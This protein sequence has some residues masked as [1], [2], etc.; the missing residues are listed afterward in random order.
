MNAGY[1]TERVVEA[2]AHYEHEAFTECAFNYRPASQ[3]QKPLYTHETHWVKLG[4]Q[5][6][7]RPFGR[8]RTLVHSNAK[9]CSRWVGPQTQAGIQREFEDFACRSLLLE[10][11]VFMR[12]TPENA[13]KDYDPKL[14]SQ[15]YQSMVG[16]EYPLNM[17][18]LAMTLP[19]GGH[20]RLDAW[21]RKFEEWKLEHGPDAV[22]LADN[23][24][25][26]GDS[27][28]QISNYPSLFPALLCH[29]TV[30]NFQ[31]EVI[32]TP[33]EHLCAMGID[34]FAEP[35]EAS[36][37]PLSELILSQPR[38]LSVR[39]IGNGVHVTLLAY[40]Y[41]YCWSNTRRITNPEF[42]KLPPPYKED[43]EELPGDD[44]T[45]SS[46]AETA[47]QDPLEQQPEEQQADACSISSGFDSLGDVPQDHMDEDNFL[48]ALQLQP[49]SVA[50]EERADVVLG[51][52]DRDSEVP[53]H[54]A[55]H[56]V[57]SS[58][59]DNAP[60]PLLDESIAS[61]VETM[62]PALPGLPGIRVSHQA[63]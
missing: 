57:Q 47:L 37:S 17:E 33:A 22:F 44:D 40:W 24:H 62:E 60:P 4:P 10:G 21:D 13:R 61:F 16:T 32:A 7:G 41:V 50:Q 51:N 15:K 42:D 19:A 2:E 49:E 27:G 29:G 55:A 36:W 59:S 54:D 38:K 53:H 46:G 6:I 9:W 48:E 56:I 28:G 30:V 39:I 20:R 1:E 14:A 12:D 31:K 5:H 25:W 58:W 26:P 63:S 18:T 34:S 45:S 35:T 8:S 52:A 23:D 3:I 11:D 43:E